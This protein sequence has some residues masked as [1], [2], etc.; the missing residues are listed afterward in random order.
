MGIVPTPAGVW[1]W[2]GFQTSYL[3]AVLAMYCF[4][5]GLYLLSF[6][7]KFIFFQAWNFWVEDFLKAECLYR[8]FTHKALQAWTW[9]RILEANINKGSLHSMVFY[10]W[11][12]GN[13]I[14]AWLGPI[15]AWSSGLVNLLLVLGARL[16]TKPNHGQWSQAGSWLLQ[17]WM[18]KKANT[19]KGSNTKLGLVL[20]A[21][22]KK[23]IVE[24]LLYPLRFYELP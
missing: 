24:T 11:D 6:W 12:C 9:M 17:L 20:W 13:L 7:V 19:R 8:C 3:E 14:I 21:L 2:S 1:L 15:M 4:Y 10:C 5:R 16:V 23:Y 22:W 18:E